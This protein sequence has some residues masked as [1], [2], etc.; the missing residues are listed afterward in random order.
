MR[1]NLT[2]VDLVRFVLRELA[3]TREHRLDGATGQGVFSL[4]DE[5]VAITGDELDKP[6]GDKVM[7]WPRETRD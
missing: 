7:V 6:R 2:K 4:D 3:R 5:L 1:G